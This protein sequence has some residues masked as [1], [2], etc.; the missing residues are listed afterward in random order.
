MQSYARFKMGRI[1][2]GI[3]IDNR[4][5]NKFQKYQ[6]LISIIKSIQDEQKTSIEMQS[7]SL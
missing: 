2:G 7:K 1:D 6:N 4:A 5:W 3:V